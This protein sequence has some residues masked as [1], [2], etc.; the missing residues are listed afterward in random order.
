M[1]DGIYK[2][3]SIIP[4]AVSITHNL[5]FGILHIPALTLDLFPVYW[6]IGYISGHIIAIPLI[7]GAISKIFIIDPLNKLFFFNINST[8]FL[9]AFCGG[10]VLC[11]AITGI[12][13]LPKL[14]YQY[15]SRLIY[16]T[17]IKF[18]SHTLGFIAKDIDTLLLFLALSINFIFM[19]YFKFSLLSQIYL[20]FFTFVCTYQIID[21]AG[22]IG[23]AQLGR[24]ATFVMVPAIFIFNLNFIQITFIATFVEICAGV[25]TDL[26]FGRKVAQLA[27]IPSNTIK[28]YQLLGIFISSITVGIV[29]WFLI[30]HFSLGSTELFAQRAQARALLINAISFNHYVLLLGFIFGYALKKLKINPMLVLGG[31]LMPINISLGLITGSFCTKFIKDKEKGECFWSGVFASHSIWMIVQAIF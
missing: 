26:L 15:F 4:K 18:K 1:Q 30:N 6:A 17:K 21:I 7:A 2:I 14:L 5:K 23:L 10:I 28:K 20:T 16:L 11:G 3:K 9:L 31:I 22:K 24:F 27:S 29:F 13:A 25:S 8:A 19:T 12:V